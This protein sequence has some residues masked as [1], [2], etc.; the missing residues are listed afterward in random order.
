MR[1]TQ[2]LA[3]GLSSGALLYFTHYQN[4]SNLLF[5]WIGVF[6]LAGICLGMLFLAVDGNT[7]R[8]YQQNAFLFWMAY[9]NYFILYPFLKFFSR[10]KVIKKSEQSSVFTIV[11]LVAMFYIIFWVLDLI[12]PVLSLSKDFFNGVF[13]GAAIA[14]I[15]QL[16]TPVGATLFFPFFKFRIHGRESSWK[17][18]QNRVNLLIFIPLAIILIEFILLIS[19][20]PY[21]SV[22][23]MFDLNT[24]L[25]PLIWAGFLYSSGVLSSVM[26]SFRIQSSHTSHL[27]KIPAHNA[28][29][30]SDVE[31]YNFEELNKER[32]K[33]GLS[34]LQF[35][36]GYANLSRSHSHTMAKTGKI[37]HADNVHK[38]HGGFSGENCAMMLKGH[39]LGISH[40]IKTEHDV[41]KALHRQWMKSPGHRE[42]ILTPGFNYVGIGVYRQ[43]HRYY[44]TQLFSS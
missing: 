20:S 15:L 12:V 13:L 21:L 17:N 39:V 22:R 24:L 34:A 31:K 35:D 8:K 28:H 30:L 37:F 26:R 36:N 41:A 4:T 1:L 5:T 11:V 10:K 16:G 38:T 33:H 27:P 2:Y 19:T 29:F 23:T 42:N 43:G 7:P 3:I 14:I 44:A 18:Y 32:K 25:F 40:T 9:L 6:F